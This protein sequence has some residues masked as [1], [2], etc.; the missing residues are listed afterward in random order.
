[1]ADRE[2]FASDDDLVFVGE[3]GG[4]LDGSALRR[5]YTA[6]LKRAGLRSLRFHDLRHTFGT[7]MIAKADIRRVQEWMGHADIQTTMRYLHYAPREEDAQ[8]IAEAFQTNLS[9]AALAV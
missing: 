2:L 5:R 7:R 6:A 3:A 4:F 9:S 1:L 8:L